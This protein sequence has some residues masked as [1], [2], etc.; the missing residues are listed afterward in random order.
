MNYCVYYIQLFTITTVHPNQ[1]RTGC[2]RGLGVV[3]G[4][5]AYPSIPVGK[6]EKALE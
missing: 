2:L 1:D 3:A 5:E 4:A 6:E